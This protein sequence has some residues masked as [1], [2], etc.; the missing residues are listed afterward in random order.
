MKIV[1]FLSQ[2]N[3]NCYG[4][5]DSLESRTAYRIEGDIF[6]EYTITKEKQAAKK[7]L[8]PVY[9]P[10]IL[11]MGLNYQ[12]HADETGVAYP[13]IPVMFLKATTAVIGHEECI[14]LPRAGPDS[15]DYE[16]ELAVIIGR[17]AK[18][19]SVENAFDYILGYTC[20]NDVSARD[21][22]FD[23]Q[24][25]Q[26]ARGKSFDT[27]CPIG[28]FLVTKDEIENPDD[29]TVQTIINGTLFQDSRTS[30]M[31]FNVATI[32]SNASQSMTLLPG[33]VILT[34]TPQ[35]VGFVRIP[36]R[37][38]AVGDNVT[39]KIEKIGELKNQVKN[40]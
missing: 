36:P 18:N 29:L 21:W 38:L 30:D 24:K 3:K 7:F 13:E 25:K 28:P 37:F 20:A 5:L 22:Q 33:T 8:P 15:V 9:P 27:F 6:S 40:E 1:H 17:Q 16:A 2:D 39:V 4:V 26:W 23:K 19:I 31:I 34:G 14:L 32:V 10:N 35:G 11:A 12:R